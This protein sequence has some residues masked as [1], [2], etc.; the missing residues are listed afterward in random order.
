MVS[1]QARQGTF[2]TLFIVEV[3][4]GFKNSI[5]HTQGTTDSLMAEQTTILDTPNHMVF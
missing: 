2:C 4:N 1:S 3:S 5:A